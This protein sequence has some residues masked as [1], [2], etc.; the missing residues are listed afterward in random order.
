MLGEQRERVAMSFV[1]V[2]FP[3]MMSR[4]RSE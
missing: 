4:S 2:S 3:A 1:V